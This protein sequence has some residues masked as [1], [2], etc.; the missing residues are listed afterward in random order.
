MAI[1]LFDWDGDAMV[2]RAAFKKR[3]DEEF[4]VGEIYRLEAREERS[5]N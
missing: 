3:C 2:P 5:I 4:V 1:A